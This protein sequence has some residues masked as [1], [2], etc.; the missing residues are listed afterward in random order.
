MDEE[1]KVMLSLIVSALRETADQAYHA[2]EMAWRTYA[3]MV[4][5]NPNFPE[6]YQSDTGVA[7][8]Q[9]VGARDQ[10]HATLDRIAERLQD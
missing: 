7:F 4:R 10:I 9:I 8:G 2:H 1:T 3:A 6:E 5:M